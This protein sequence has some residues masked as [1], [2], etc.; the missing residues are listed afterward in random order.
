MVRFDATIT[1]REKREPLG[2]DGLPNRGI[3]CL[4]GFGWRDGAA[5]FVGEPIGRIA[6]HDRDTA[7]A[8]EDAWSMLEICG[9]EGDARHESAFD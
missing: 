8:G 7:G 9:G 5:S 6:V 3:G 4:R 2:K 1:G